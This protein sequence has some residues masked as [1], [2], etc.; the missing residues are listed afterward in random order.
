M[1][2]EHEV[3]Y[4]LDRSDMIVGV[5]Q[6]WRRFAAANHGAGLLP[7]EMCTSSSAATVRRSVG[8]WR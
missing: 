2:H 5:N 7:P 4:T 8:C 1:S 3:A 6:G